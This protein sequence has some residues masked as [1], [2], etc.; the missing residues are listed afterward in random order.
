LAPL[1]KLSGVTKSFPGI[2]ANDNVDLN[3]MP[4][5][6]H[7]LLGENGAGKS[8]LVKIIYGLL[9]PDSGL[10]EWQGT[11]L[12]IFG[13]SQARSLGIG[14]VFQHFSLFDALTVCENIAI[15][16]DSNLGLKTLNSKI[17][18]V[19]E[20]Y[21]L[22]LAPDRYVHSLSVGEKQRVEI[23]RCLLQNP[24]LLIL[25][26]PTSVL[27]PQE[28]ISLFVTLETLAASGCAI[29][30]I[31]HKLE[32][33][34]RICMKA[35]I[36]RNGAVVATCDPRLETAR[37]MAE[38]M[39]GSKLNNIQR[40]KRPKSGEH[41]VQINKLSLK[42]SDPFGVNL[43]SISLNISRGEVVGIA[44]VAGNGQNELM[45]ALSGEVIQSLPNDSIV[46][47]DICVAGM[48][49]S[50]RRAMGACFVP[51]ER[52][53][54][55]AIKEMSLK[56]NALLTSSKSINLVKKGLLQFD[57]INDLT[58]KIIFDF[59]VRT[60]GS[61]MESGSLSGGNLQKFILGREILQEPGILIIS[62]P[63][64]GVDAGAALVLRKSLLELAAQGCAVLIIS[65]DLDEIFEI[66]DR[67]AVLYQGT[68][69][70]LMNKET[71]SIDQIG[72]LM[73]GG[74]GE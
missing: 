1:L 9:K 67:I 73:G 54:H 40:P 2:L 46:F 16:S 65:Q 20:D 27:T 52:Y 15:A 34:K 39:I 23:I 35:T 14:M 7:A 55:A 57:A 42:S 50:E 56:D 69:S 68:L 33:V 53:G 4:G 10:L 28:A 12:K 3:V 38:R 43:K 32:E 13:P 45:A 70:A 71:V 6:I 59:D 41:R 60:T 61:K 51:E 64:W 36:L 48:R 30:Y 37:T 29:L 58:E 62:Q 47:D 18:E 66:C 26:E 22:P 8:T 24:K 49:V 31:S 17:M 5:E 19:S 44:G 25:D 72:L 21:G 74:N 11:Q 63:T